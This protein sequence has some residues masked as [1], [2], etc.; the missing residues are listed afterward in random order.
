MADEFEIIIVQQMSNVVFGTAG[1]VIDA[2]HF[3]T[4]GYQPVAQMR[5]EETRPTRNHHWLGHS[6]R[7]DLP[8]V[9]LMPTRGL[10]KR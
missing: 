1:E 8:R 2:Q 10:K 4:I 6:K 7:P 3:V 5:T 9:W